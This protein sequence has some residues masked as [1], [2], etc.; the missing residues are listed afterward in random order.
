MP[1]RTRTLST[2]LL[3]LHPT[4]VRNHEAPV[5]CDEL[6]LDLNR[7]SRIVVL[8]I[9]CN[10]GTSNGLTDSVNLRG[11][12]TTLHANANIDRGESVLADDQNRLVDLE[13]EDLRLEEVDRGAIDLDEALTLTAM[14]D[15]GRCLSENEHRIM[16]TLQEITHLL[17]AKSLDGVVRSHV[18]CNNRFYD[19]RDK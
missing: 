9:V 3:G 17:F 7:R 10:N 12:S 13:A 19:L 15:S 11:V 1:A 16:Y 18:R 4:R 14:G 6:L 5:V 8:C 2:E